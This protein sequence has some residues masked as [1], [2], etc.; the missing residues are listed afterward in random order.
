MNVPVLIAAVLS[1]LAF[2]AHTFM[3]DRE[4]QLLRP[5]KKQDDA[6]NRMEKWTMSRCGWHWISFDLFA[7]STVLF[8]ILF[9]NIII[10]EQFLLTLLGLYY[11]GYGTV[12]LITIKI[13]K[14]FPYNYFR[15]WQW[16]LLYIIG[17]LVFWGSMT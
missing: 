8:L 9:T 13:S 17:G 7:T 2:L 6:H 5:E 1:G 12:W 11:F 14:P 3:G 4:I 15:L 16:S 10:H